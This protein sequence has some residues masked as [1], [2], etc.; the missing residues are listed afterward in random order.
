MHL[1]KHDIVGALITGLTAGF[2]GWKVFDYVG[3][4]QVAG[5]GW[6]WLV[7][8]IPIA[9]IAG[10]ELGYL[11]AR[12]W[13]F[14]E[15]FGKFAAIGFT[16]SAVD[17]GIFNFIFALSGQRHEYFIISNIISFCI[18]A[19]HSFLWN[20][21]WAFGASSSEG[22]LWEIAKFISVLLS[23]VAVNTVIGY[24]AFTS[25]IALGGGTTAAANLGKIAGS[26]VALLITFIGFRLIVFKRKES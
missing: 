7:L 22:G 2:A 17:F 3:V 26:A 25:G 6:V 4:P 5:V 18:A 1:N 15:Q 11:L 24:V 13:K 8:I 10:I 21:Y 19:V 9:W 14:F 16:N 20:K 23:A 12:R